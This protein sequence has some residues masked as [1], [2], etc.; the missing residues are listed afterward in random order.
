MAFIGLVPTTG[1]VIS[2]KEGAECLP[3]PW[4]KTLKH[5][6][7]KAY[8][9]LLA[10][11]LALAFAVS[12]HAQT[13]IHIAGSTAYRAATVTAIEAALTAGGSFTYAYVGTPPL[14]AGNEKKANQAIFKGNVKISGNTVPVEFKT[15]FQGSV[16]G[17]ADL[18][19]HLTVGTGGSAYPNGGGGWLADSNLPA[20]GGAVVSSSAPLDPA[21]VADVAMSD[22][23]QTSTPF[24]STTLSGKIVGVVPFEWVKGLDTSLST[25]T[26]ITTANAY[27]LLKGS[28][29][30]GGAK[31]F[32]IGRDEDSGTRLAA[33]ED[34]SGGKDNGDIGN[35][36]YPSV[37]QQYQ[38]AA[39]GT[40][41]PWAAPVTVDGFT[42]PNAGHSGYSSGGALATDL[43][44]ATTVPY[45]AYLGINDA[46]SVNTGKNGLQF[47][48]HPYSVTN[49]GSGA[50]TFWGYEH[51]LFLPTL[52]GTPLLV[53]QQL[54]TF[55]AS[56]A[57]V[58]GVAISSMHVHRNGDGQPIL[59]GGTPPNSP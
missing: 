6:Y 56:N 19:N 15:S 16:G 8:K 43:N 54:E 58:S 59:S 25:L 34:A 10:S 50:Y 32:A 30:F 1:A 28:F 38:F 22:S 20:S 9:T 51:L 27:N 46:G 57:S 7:V 23:F 4:V 5:K 13:V 55:V 45:V 49:V 44:K 47:N 53:A 21:S 39:S 48:S 42:Y 3:L 37:P 41:A 31:V 18:V 35:A 36:P 29:T 52:S 40:P 12:A 17:V 24:T 11:S 2:T 26:N 14:V 33:Y